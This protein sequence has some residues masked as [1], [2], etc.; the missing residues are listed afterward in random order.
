MR[1]RHRLQDYF[2]VYA[3]ARI[4]AASVAARV[5]DNFQKIRPRH[6]E[7]RRVNPERLVSVVPSAGELSIDVHPGTHH[8]AVE[9]ECHRTLCVALINDERPA[10]RADAAPRQLA[11][12]AVLGCRVK[13]P[14]YRPV[15]RNR[16]HAPGSA[17]QTELPSVCEDAFFAECRQ[18]KYGKKNRKNLCIHHLDNRKSQML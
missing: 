14:F 5:G 17:V 13:R 1:L 2:A 12:V 11:G 7:R 10:V 8:H 4:P 6:D 3:P 9:V 18:R 16:N 15:V